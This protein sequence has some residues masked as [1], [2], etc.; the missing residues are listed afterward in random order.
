MRKSLVYLLLLAAVLAACGT[1]RTNTPTP[2]AA[3]ATVEEATEEAVGE[4]TEEATEAVGEVTQEATEETRAT[5][6]ESAAEATEEGTEEATEVAA[7]PT[8]RP[9]EAATRE[10]TE[11]ATSEATEEATREATE[12]ATPEAMELDATFTSD[13]GSI[14]FMYPSEWV[15]REANGQILLASSEAALTATDEMPSSGEFRAAI[16]VSAITDMDTGLSAGATPVEVLQAV[17]DTL[18]EAGLVEDLTDM[19]GDEAT[20][21]AEATQQAEATVEAETK[22]AF[23]EPEATTIGMHDAA[24]MKGTLVDG[25]V[26]LWAID[27]GDDVFAVIT[28]AS[29]QG[30]MAGFEQTLMAVAETLTYTP[31]EATQAAG[32]EATSEATAEATEQTGG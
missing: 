25:E 2:G 12:E 24:R 18:R 6:T 5:P 21:A 22:M 15:V 10:A 20:E 11:E 23:E 3:A 4:A 19:A 17:A 30:E 14:T 31:A 8:E 27:L 28:A 26:S 7:A 16:V 9:T 32:A 29:A 1:P 13:D